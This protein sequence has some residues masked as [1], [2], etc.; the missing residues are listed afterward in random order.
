VPGSIARVLKACLQKDPERR[1]QSAKDLRNELR[2]IREEIASGELPAAGVGAAPRVSRQT[3]AAM[4]ILGGLLVLATAAIGYLLWNRGDT[5]STLPVMRHLQMTS[6]AG[7]EA[8][9]R[10]S[11]D[12]KW[13]VYVA[14]PAGNADIF[15][16]AERAD[17][18]QPHQ[19]L[20]GP[21]DLSVVLSRRRTHRVPIE[22]RRRRALR[23]GTHGRSAS[24]A[25]E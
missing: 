13:L 23:D 3:P 4:P 5:S 14:A 15:L 7:S 2:T 1:F 10:L 24:P 21:G 8:M 12:G 16:Q 25:H 11:P 18:H 20:E 17:G 19:G 6:A 9:P 22:P